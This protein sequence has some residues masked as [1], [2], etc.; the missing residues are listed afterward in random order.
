MSPWNEATSQAYL[1]LGKQ[2]H[3]PILFPEIE[4]MCGGFVGKRVLDFGCGEGNLSL[5]IANAGA[6]ELICADESLPMIRQARKNLAPAEEKGGLKV[7]CLCGNESLLPF[8]LKSDVVLCCLALMME[9]SRGR[10]NRAVQGLIQ[11]VARGG[12]LLIILTHPCFSRE[13]HS[14]FQLDLPDRFDYWSSGAPLRVVLDP[15]GKE[16]TEILDYHWTLE[17]YSSA[18][19]AGGGSIRRLRELPAE[20]DEAGQPIGNPAYLILEI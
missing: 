1:G 5:C 13:V 9:G 4:K 16:E 7:S 14:T 6:S 18:I 3:I 19:F 17:D 15:P 11:S 12:K 8:P 2:S 20:R 10:L